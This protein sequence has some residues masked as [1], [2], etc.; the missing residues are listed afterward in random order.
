LAHNGDISST[1]ALYNRPDYQP[2]TQLTPITQVLSQPYVAVVNPSV[3][4]KNIAELIELIKDK[5]SKGQ[6][7]SYAT[8]SLGSAEHLAGE[9]FRLASGVNMQA[10]PYKSSAPA[11]TDVAGGHVP[12]GFFSLATA[13]PLTK[14]GAVRM[15]GIS[16]EKRLDIWPAVP[17][18]AETLPGYSSRAWYGFFGPAGMSSELTEK[19][20]RA[21]HAAVNSPSLKTLMHGNGQ[22]AA[23]ST[24]AEFIE[25]LRVDIART[26]D[27]IQK[28][29]I[30]AQ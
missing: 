24:P 22:S 6:K 28:A 23:L 18:V 8:G 10:I 20:N 2:L 5:N 19:I 13:T 30:T 25:F 17:T 9:Q 1:A 27:Y 16:T 3:P 15:L 26:S 21:I 29:N 12:F 11:I 14:A 7:Y 4:A